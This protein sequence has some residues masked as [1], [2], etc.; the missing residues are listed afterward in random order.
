MGAGASA[1]IDFEAIETA[2]KREALRVAAR[3]IER[4]LDADLSDYAGPSLP[5]R[6]G[7]DASYAGRMKK[8]FETAVGAVTLRRAYYHCDSC[9]AGWCPRDAALG[10]LR[11]SLS[12]AVLRMTGLVAARVSFAESEVLLWELGG[13]R[14]EAKHV[15]RAAESLGAEVARDELSVVDEPAAWEPLAPTLYLGMD[16]TGVPMRKEELEGRAG[17]QPDG[18]AKTREAKLCTV[19]SAEKRDEQGIPVRDPGSVTYSAA[20]ESAATRDTDVVPSAFAQRVEREARRRGF[21]SAARSVVLGDGAPWIWNLASELF[22]N[23]LQIVDR[24]H[25]KANLTTIAKAIWGPTS[26]LGGHWAKCRHDE[27]DAGQIDALL[28]ALEVHAGSNDEARRGVGYFTT[29]RARMRYPEFRDWGLCTSTGVLEAG[30]GVAIGARLKG[31]GMH[32]TVR[33][34][35]AILALRTTILSGRFEDFWDRRARALAA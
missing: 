35:N 25:A 12:P 4:R 28:A 22:P 33:G 1:G 30:C 26:A 24:F 6:C 21:Y 14:V 32:W 13:V 31:S 34:A 15:E 8:T 2:A 10:M 3:A 5:C 20:I 16:G 27:L 19:W 17:K 11:R 18:H 23:A 7:R 9:H 29:N